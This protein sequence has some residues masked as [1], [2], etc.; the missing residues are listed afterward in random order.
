VKEI[1][2][3]LLGCAREC[4]QSWAEFQ[5]D[6]RSERVIGR[7]SRSQFAALQ[8]RSDSLRPQKIGRSRRQCGHFG[9]TFPDRNFGKND[10]IRTFAALDF[11]QRTLVVA[12]RFAGSNFLF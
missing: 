2:N 7:S 3:G 12:P 5:Q 4:G 8:S 6:V 11:S 9:W 1:P 10:P